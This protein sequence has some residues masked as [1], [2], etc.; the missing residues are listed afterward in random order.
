[1]AFFLGLSIVSIL[2]C[3]CYCCTWSCNQCDNDNEEE[4]ER[5]RKIWKD[6]NYKNIFFFAFFL[7]LIIHQTVSYRQDLHF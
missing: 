5:I 7:D 6:G 3:I 4:E 1:M 2:E